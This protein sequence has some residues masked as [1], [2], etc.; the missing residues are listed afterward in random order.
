MGN[1][2]W[3][4]DIYSFLVSSFYSKASWGTSNQLAVWWKRDPKTKYYMNAYELI[5]SHVFETV[6]HI[7]NKRPTEDDKIWAIAEITAYFY[8]YR[9][10]DMVSNLWPW[11]KDRVQKE[12]AYEHF[13][14]GSYKQ[15]GK[16][17]ED[18]YNFYT[19]QLPYQDY[20]KEAIQYIDTYTVDY[21]NNPL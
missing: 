6:D 2:D 9:E 12:T 13:Y 17:A 3:K 11:L 8:V 21:L 19:K 20:L 14:N 4:F 16:P 18:L 15:L 1:I 7:Y 10:A 5:L